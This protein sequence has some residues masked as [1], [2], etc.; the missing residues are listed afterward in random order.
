MAFASSAF[1][2]NHFEFLGVPIDGPVAL[3]VQQLRPMGFS[4][5]GSPGRL[6]VMQGLYS[7]F[8]QSE[9]VIESLPQKSC[10]WGL[11]VHS[12]AHSDWN[13]LLSGYYTMK[14]Q[15]IRTYGSP[16]F[17]TERFYTQVSTNAD[18]LSAL[19]EGTATYKSVFETEDGQVDLVIW[20]DEQYGPHL[21]L[22]FIDKGNSERHPFNL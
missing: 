22:S 17:S 8:G 7:S 18:C 5:V 13:T 12:S 20:N 6:S 19:A 16:T 14:S 1:A 15:L 9:I 11:T 21:L 10:V 3:F 4:P 2:K